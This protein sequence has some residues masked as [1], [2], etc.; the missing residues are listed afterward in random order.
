MKRKISVFLALVMMLS[1]MFS[2]GVSAVTDGDILVAPAND[3]AYKGLVLGQS[4]NGKLTT[5]NAENT[6]VYTNEGEKGYVT[7]AIE[8]TEE[9]EKVKGGWVVE[10]YDEEDKLIRSSQAVLN[11]EGELPNWKFFASYPVNGT[12]TVKVV[13][14]DESNAPLDTEYTLRVEQFNKNHAIFDKFLGFDLSVFEWIQSIQGK[15][16]NTFMVIVTTLGDEG[17]IFIAIALVFLFTKKY[18]KIGFAMLIALGVMTICNNLVLKEL[19][20]RPR[21]YMLYGVDPEAY[22]LW[23]GEN[24]KYF[25]PNLVHYHTSYSFPSGHTSSAFAAAF[26]ILF[27]NRKIGIP[28]TLFAALMGFSRIFVEVHFCTDVI[29]GAIVGFVYALIAAVIINILYP[30]FEKLIE[31]VTKKIK[32][33]KA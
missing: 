21:P 31:A 24:A 22:A 5:E 18:R 14:A 28:M 23:G 30:Y 10:V 9:A 20:A 8:A 27:Y 19:V 33:E 13:A 12:Y 15:F 29:A 6:F 25:F 3:A 1:L 16:M 2:F 32:K 7:F 4:Y 17:I 26:A 11:E